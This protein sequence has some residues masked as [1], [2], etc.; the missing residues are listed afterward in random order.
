MEDFDQR[1]IESEINNELARVN[2]WLKLN[3]L[4]LNI[5]KTNLMIFGRKQK[6]IKEINISI[7]NVQIER[8]HTFNFLGIMLDE[9]LPWTDH[10]NM[11][12]NKISRVTDVLYRLKSVFPKEIL[13]TLYNTLI[14]SSISY[15]LLVWGVKSNR[16]E[17]PQIKAIRLVTNSTYFAHTTSLFK[18][19]GL[20]KVY[21]IFKL[22][23]L[24]L[25]YKLLYDLLL[26]YFNSYHDVIDKE[27]PRVLR[28]HFIH[29]PMIK[30]VLSV[31]F[32]IN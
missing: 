6:K 3:K 5:K 28:Q 24:K 11:V 10:T 17:V 8:V 15:G 29:Q 2:I 1:R 13:L 27:P 16:I 9:S 18:S 4:S 14:V 23:L 25:F 20:L 26:P 31:L 30:R 32:Y 19:E 12:A 21:D 7:D 22:K